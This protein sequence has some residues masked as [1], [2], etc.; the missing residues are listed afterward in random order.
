M[1]MYICTYIP[2]RIPS[3]NTERV[4]FQDE[5]DGMGGGGGMRWGRP[6]PE[7]QLCVCAC[8]STARDRTR[9]G[10]V[11]VCVCRMLLS[12]NTI[13][14]YESY[15]LLP[16]ARW[17]VDT[18]AICR[19]RLLEIRVIPYTISMYMPLKT[20]LSAACALRS[21]QCRPYEHL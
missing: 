8:G 19:A 11:C 15:A 9:V 3:H 14:A 6:E 18:I 13:D 7:T 4:G 20:G 21:Y 5:S 17:P 16:L 1:Y 10:S 12:S 2:A